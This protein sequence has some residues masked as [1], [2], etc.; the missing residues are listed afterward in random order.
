M[1]LTQQHHGVTWL[2]AVG[3]A[4][5][6]SRERLSKLH[7]AWRSRRAAVINRVISNVPEADPLTPKTQVTTTTTTAACQPACLS[8]KPGC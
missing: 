3:C 8:I 5:S 7:G 6:S 1:M 4:Q 2:W